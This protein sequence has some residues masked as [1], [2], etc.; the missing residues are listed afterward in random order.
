MTLPITE[1]EWEA[2]PRP[3]PLEPDEVDLYHAGHIALMPCP[4]CGRHPLTHGEINKRNGNVIYH[5]SCH[6]MASTIGVASD[7]NKARELAIEHWS[8]R[9]HAETIDC[10]HCGYTDKRDNFIHA[11]GELHANKPTG[12]LGFSCPHCGQDQ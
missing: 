7:R 11:N 6:C 1:A 10:S 8:K 9:S 12:A 2:T 3:V 5:V 4:F